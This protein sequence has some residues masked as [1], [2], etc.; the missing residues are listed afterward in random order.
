MTNP[1]LSFKYRL[2]K[3]IIDCYL[4]YVLLKIKVNIAI[5]DMSWYCFFC[6]IH[7]NPWK[8]MIKFLHSKMISVAKHPSHRTNCIQRILL[9]YIAK[10]KP[11]QL[12]YIHCVFCAL[13]QR[14]LRS[15]WGWCLHC[16]QSHMRTATY[17]GWPRESTAV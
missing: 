5:T 2:E 4:W 7:F 1:L 11:Y 6:T 9:L 17:K 8:D 16:C 13:W 15:V 3:A 10:C 12:L 14:L